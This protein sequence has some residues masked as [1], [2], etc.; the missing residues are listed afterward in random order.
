MQHSVSLQEI[1]DIGRWLQSLGLSFIN[2]SLFKRPSKIKGAL[3][4]LVRPLLFSLQIKLL[5]VLNFGSFQ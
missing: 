2:S 4:S 1:S 3:R 5:P